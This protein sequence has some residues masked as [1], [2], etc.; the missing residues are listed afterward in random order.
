[1]DF[2]LT[3]QQE[4]LRKMARDFL[5]RECPS[6]LVRQMVEDEK[7]YSPELW[8]E[9][10]QLGWME[11]I[12]PQEYSGSEGNFL[13]LCVLLEEMGRVCLPSPFFSTIVLGAL[14][15]IDAGS[16][17]QKREL[18]PKVAS[19]QMLLTLALTEPSARW[20]AKGVALKAIPDGDNYILNGTKLFVPD[21]NVSDFIVVV[22]RTQEG[23]KGEEGIT[24]FLLNT[25]DHSIN[26]T[27]LKT[28]SGDKQCSVVFNHVKINRKNVLGEVDKGWQIIDKVLDKATAAKCCEMVG[29][30]QRVLE[31]AVDYAKQRVQFGRPIGSFQAIQY[32]CANM[33][34]DVDGSRFIAYQAVWRVSEGLPCAKEVAW[35]KAWVSEAYRRVTALGHQIFGAIGFCEDH[36][37]PLYS[38]RAKASELFLGDSFFH[39]DKIAQS[40]D[41]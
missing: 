31:M 24:L 18:L 21:A 30:A 1:M 13:D 4:M 38:K 22:A 14:L 19:G 40:L 5:S 32:Y 11:L 41:I 17:E 15:I 39:Q 16:E 10:A 34:T 25:K 35:A 23:M 3:E 2:A 28:I 26:I 37:M 20:D 8:E 7:G 27:P 9:M 12:L 29:G 36:D 33:A 6:S